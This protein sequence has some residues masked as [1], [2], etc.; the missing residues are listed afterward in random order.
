MH[1]VRIDGQTLKIKNSD[2]KKLYVVMQKSYRLRQREKFFQKNFSDVQKLG[3]LGIDK[4][5]WVCYNYITNSCSVYIKTK[6]D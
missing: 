3:H 5:F 4:L 2:I 1:T 6:G